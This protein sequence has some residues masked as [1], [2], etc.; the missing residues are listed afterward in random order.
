MYFWATII[1][2]H[3]TL[4]GTLPLTTGH[5][6]APSPS[7]L[8]TYRHALPHIC[9]TCDLLTHLFHFGYSKCPYCF[10]TIP[11]QLLQEGVVR[12]QCN[13]SCLLWSN[14]TEYKIFSLTP[15]VI[16]FN[17]KMTFWGYSST[18]MHIAL[19]HLN[20]RQMTQ[21]AAAAATT[22]IILIIIIW[23]FV[24]CHDMAQVTTRITDNKGACS[25]LISWLHYL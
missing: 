13:L 24:R 1:N 4:T 17:Q 10:P 7:R 5:L 15:G 25:N 3:W 11:I 6:Q 22:T 19:Q 21:L 2:T 20:S 9:H 14:C 8:D 18:H 16:K 12:F 23:Q